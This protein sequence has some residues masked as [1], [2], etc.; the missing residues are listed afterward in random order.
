MK[1][2]HQFGGEPLADGEI[3][4]TEPWCLNRPESVAYGKHEIDKLV[5]A[6]YDV[7]AFDG[8]GYKNFYACFCPVCRERQAAYR[9]QHLELT[10]AQAVRQCSEDRLVAF[11]TELVQYAKLK[12]PSVKTTCHIWPYFA[13]DPFYGNRIPFDYCGQTVSWFFLPHWPLDKVE[14]GAAEVVGQAG[15]YCPQ[16]VGAPF[17]ALCT[18]PPNERH[19]KSAERVR[20]EIRL[21]K[22]AG[23][24]AIQFAELGNILHDPAV[25]KVVSEELGGTWTPAE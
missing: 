6:G 22:R 14:R 16:S 20:E 18:L 11:L 7:I 23:A 12:K 25:A 3:A 4:Q 1:E 10:E 24:T 5:A 8:S 17:I 19:R 13:P 21:V 9:R 2:R 15:R